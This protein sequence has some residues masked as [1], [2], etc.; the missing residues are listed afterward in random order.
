[1]SVPQILVLALILDAM[2]G[3]PKW[4]WSRIPHPAVVMGTMVGWAEQKFNRGTHLRL[5]GSLALA[6]L[7]SGAALAGSALA[8]LPFGA[9]PEVIVAGVLVAHRSLADHV[10][11]VARALSVSPDEARLAVARIVGRDTA[12]MD[13]AAIARAAIESAAENFSDGVV[14][15]VFWFLVFGLPGMLAYKMVNTADSMIGYLS[16]RYREFGW[17]SARLDDLLNWVP[18]RLSA[19]I[20]LAAFGRLHGCR[21][22]RRDARL[23]RSPNAGWPEA[24]MAVGLDVALAGPRS[25]EGEMHDFPW[26]HPEG[27]KHPGATDV[28]RAVL[29]LW[30]GWAVLLFLVGL[31]AVA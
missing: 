18:A 2:A 30:R 26:V 1:M 23:H 5:V 11:S 20:I 28:N 10:R 15:P 4:I 12:G 17:S 13:D 29:A 31:L 27:R 19:L 22:V 24:A 21:I 7:V 9:W 16:P 25:Y 8:A 6:A 3:E 14:A